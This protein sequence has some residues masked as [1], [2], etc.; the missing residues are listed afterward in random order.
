MA[1]ELEVLGRGVESDVVLIGLV[2]PCVAGLTKRDC[3]AT[4]ISDS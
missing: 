4:V 3:K 2:P 1:H